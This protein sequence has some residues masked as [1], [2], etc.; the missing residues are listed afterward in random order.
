VKKKFDNAWR[1]ILE[2]MDEEVSATITRTPVEKI[3]HTLI[4][5]TYAHAL[6]SI[7]LKNPDILHA[8]NTNR[9]AVS[10]CSQQRSAGRHRCRRRRHRRRRCCRRMDPSNYCVTLAFSL[11]T[12]VY[13]CILLE[14]LLPLPC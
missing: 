7:C 4:S 14:P 10:T 8:L 2:L 5:A 11:L 6:R 1:P 13:C 9:Q 3:D 12:L